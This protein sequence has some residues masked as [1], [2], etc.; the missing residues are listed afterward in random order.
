MTVG[1]FCESPLGSIWYPGALQLAYDALRELRG[2]VDVMFLPIM[3]LYGAELPVLELVRPRTVVPI[4]Y[5]E[6]GSSW[7]DGLSRMMLKNFDSEGRPRDGAMPGDVGAEL[8]ALM[9]R[10]WVRHPAK[11]S[12]RLAQLRVIVEG[13]GASFVPVETGTWGALGANGEIVRV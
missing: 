3:S 4:E 8:R 6:P 9:N 11:V 2:R 7:A 5:V 12:E 1:F 13:I 10:G